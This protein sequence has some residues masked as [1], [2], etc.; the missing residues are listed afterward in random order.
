MGDCS[1]VFGD[2]LCQILGR[3]LIKYSIKVSLQGYVF[4]RSYLDNILGDYTVAFDNKLCQ[5]S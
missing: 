1:V 3:F 2:I 4:D 5:I